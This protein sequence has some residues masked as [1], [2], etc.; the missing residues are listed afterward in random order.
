MARVQTTKKCAYCGENFLTF[1]KAQKY[2]STECCKANQKNLNAYRTRKQHYEP[3]VTIL[4]R[5]TLSEWELEARACRLDYGN[6]RGLIEKCGRTFEEL[7]AVQLDLDG[8][9]DYFSNSPISQ[10]GSVLT[11][12]TQ[13]ILKCTKLA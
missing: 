10:A 2:C 8:L 6:Y 1:N 11:A 3:T 9:K 7:V 5:K 13:G 4:P 12:L